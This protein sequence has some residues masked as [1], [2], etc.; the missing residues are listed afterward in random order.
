MIKEENINCHIEALILASPEPVPVKKLSEA[1]EDLPA[2]RIRQAGSTGIIQ[3][4]RLRCGR[5]MKCRDPARIT[6]G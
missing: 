1:L 3:P 2:A 6:P 5:M 4:G